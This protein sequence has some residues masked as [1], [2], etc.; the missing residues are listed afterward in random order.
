MHQ[1][2]GHSATGQMERDLA[3]YVGFIHLKGRPVDHHRGIFTGHHTTL[4]YILRRDVK[5][6][7]RYH[8]C[9][10][11]SVIDSRTAGGHISIIPLNDAHNKPQSK[12]NVKRALMCSSTKFRETRCDTFAEFELKVDPWTVNVQYETY[13]TP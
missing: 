6:T 1:S 3:S 2:W 11:G 12:I 4:K 8:S 9:H 13:T 5:P 10:R 7:Y